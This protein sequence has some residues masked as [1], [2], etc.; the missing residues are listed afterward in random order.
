LKGLCP[1]C[2]AVCF[3]RLTLWKFFPSNATF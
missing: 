1:L 3:T 2:V